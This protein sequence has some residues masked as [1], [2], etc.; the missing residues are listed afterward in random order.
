[1]SST[2]IDSLGVATF[3]FKSDG[4]VIHEALGVTSELLYEFDEKI[5]KIISG[6]GC[7]TLSRLDDG[8]LEGPVG[9]LL[10]QK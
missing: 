8:T 9:I 4:T 7:L 2:Y 3:K 10:K 6:K 5:I 1:M